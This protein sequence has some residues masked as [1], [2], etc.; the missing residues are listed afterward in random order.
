MGPLPGAIDD[1]ADI[2]DRPE[3]RRLTR[4][5]IRDRFPKGIP[6]PL[7][8][9]PSMAKMNVTKDHKDTS[10]FLIWCHLREHD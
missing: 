3:R 4:Q 5:P 2:Q 8:G 10:S 9:R 1:V 6:L 7:K